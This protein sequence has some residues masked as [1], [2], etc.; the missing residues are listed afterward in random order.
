MTIAQVRSE[1]ISELNQL[2]IMGNYDE[3]E[4]DEY[5]N[6]VHRMIARAGENAPLF[7]DLEDEP[8]A[9]EFEYCESVQAYFVFMPIHE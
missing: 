7:L 4:V 5:V 2:A 3:S 1:I 6:A 9:D 8:D